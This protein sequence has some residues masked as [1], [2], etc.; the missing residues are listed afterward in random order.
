MLNLVF[1][2]DWAVDMHDFRIWLTSLDTV[3][4]SPTHFSWEQSQVL[5]NIWVIVDFAKQMVSSRG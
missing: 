2:I 5:S 1:L 4:M 3:G